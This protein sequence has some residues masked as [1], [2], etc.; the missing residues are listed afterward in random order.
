MDGRGWC[1]DHRIM[2]RFELGGTFKG[3]L[4]PR[5]AMSRDPAPLPW[6]H[7]PYGLK[8]CTDTLLHWNHSFQQHG[9]S[10]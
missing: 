4:V 5:A 8:E 1:R 6:L 2:E 10:P 3:H 7:R 9:I